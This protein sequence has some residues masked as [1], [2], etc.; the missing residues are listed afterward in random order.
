MSKRKTETKL[1]HVGA[2]FKNDEQRTPLKG[3]PNTNLDTYKKETGEFTTRRKY[4][5]E[6]KAQ[7]DLDAGHHDHNKNDHA[8]DF[9]GNKRSL[10]R[11]HLT[12]KEKRELNKAKRK[13]K[14]WSND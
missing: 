4:N 5:A 8:H 1:F 14:A 6:G 13:R 11:E 2:G 12:K 9:D 10:P 3:K 7:K